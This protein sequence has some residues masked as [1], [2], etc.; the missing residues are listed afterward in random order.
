[1]NRHGSGCVSSVDP[2]HGVTLSEAN[3][4]LSSSRSGWLALTFYIL[5][6]GSA[7]AGIGDVA[8]H[9]RAQNAICDQ[10]KRGEIPPYPNMCLPELPPDYVYRKS[11]DH[12]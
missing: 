11:P 2:E 8:A 4:M 7:F 10:Q 3:E 12:R 5:G 9:I 6:S 1:M